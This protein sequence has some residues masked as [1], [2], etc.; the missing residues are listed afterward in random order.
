MSKR[1]ILRW[2]I[3]KNSQQKCLRSR[4]SCP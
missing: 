1:I 2:N 3:G 4:R